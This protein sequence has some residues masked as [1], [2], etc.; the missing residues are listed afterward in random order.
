MARGFTLIE[1]TAAL[2]IM[3]LVLTGGTVL[4]FRN[5][6]DSREQETLDKLTLL[7]RAIVGDPRIVTKESRTDFGY[8]GYVRDANLNPLSG[9]SVKINY[10]SNGALTNQSVQTDAAGAYSFNDIPTGNRSVE[11]EPRLVY[12]AGSAVATPSNAGDNIQF[13]VQNY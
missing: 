9:V 7:K 1:A 11:V 13:V 10:P 6:T 12:V 2:G 4:T 3:A 5:L 8:V